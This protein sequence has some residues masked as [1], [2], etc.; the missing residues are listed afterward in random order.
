MNRLLLMALVTLV[1]AVP[2]RADLRPP[3]PPGFKQV[4]VQHRVTT[5][6]EFPDYEFFTVQVTDSRP[7]KT[8]TRQAKAA[9]LDPKTPL[10]LKTFTGGSV[11]MSYELVAVPKDAGKKYASEKDFHQALC[12]GKVA[13]QVKAATGFSGPGSTNI[14][15]SDPRKEVVH[16]YRLEKIDSKDGIVVKPVTPGGAKGPAGSP[17]PG[18]EE[19]LTAY[20]PRGGIWVAGLA[21][22][23]AVLLAGL[24]LARRWR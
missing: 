5:D 15:D 24:W 7:R 19:P 4:P 21:G 8:T 12:D 20:S 22:A 23:L 14:K 16:E 13:G 11:S 18:E 10:T 2:A 1:L 6:R 3:T 17:P 9:K